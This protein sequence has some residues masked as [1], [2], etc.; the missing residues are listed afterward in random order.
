[1]FIV[2]SKQKREMATRGQQPTPEEIQ[3][4]L[5]SLYAEKKRLINNSEGNKQRLSQLNTRI[6]KL[7]TQ[8][9][10]VQLQEQQ[11]NL[12]E[13]QWQLQ[14]QQRIFE[15]RQSQFAEQQR[16]FENQ[17]RRGQPVAFIPNPT[18][19]HTV[20]IV[21]VVLKSTS[22]ET[23]EVLQ[24]IYL[25]SS[26]LR[27]LALEKHNIQLKIG[28]QLFNSPQKKQTSQSQL[29]EISVSVSVYGEPQQ[30]INGGIQLIFIDFTS[31]FFPLP[32][33]TEQNMFHIRFTDKA[34]NVPQ[35]MC[36][37]AYYAF[38]DAIVKL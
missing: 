2:T 36:D 33:M 11:R 10:E 7:H 32:N 25:L 9:K 29:K 30:M 22:M 14:E 4:T 19:I 13:Q 3:R 27:D 21:H 18:S 12:Q 5:G 35:I 23:D 38:L 28:L 15:E 16:L 6:S 17:G 37:Q 24:K 34:G 8:L 1:M 20:R 26:H 31:P